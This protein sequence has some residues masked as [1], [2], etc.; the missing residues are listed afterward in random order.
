MNAPARTRGRRL[1]RP[2]AAL[3]AL[4]LLPTAATAAHDSEGFWSLQLENDLWGDNSDRFYTNGWQFSFASSAR[5]PSALRRFAESIP[6]YHTGDKGYFG[7]H[8]GQQVFT[9]EDI[10]ATEL[11]EDDRP[12]AGYLYAETFIGHRYFDAGDRERLNGLILTI[13][14]VGPSSLAEETQELVHSVFDSD[15][16]RGWDNQLDD[17]LGIGVTYV[18]KW[19]Y[20]FAL[21]RAKQYELGLHT[22]LRIGNVYTYAAAGV[23]ARWGTHLKGDIGPPSIKPGFPGLLAFNPQHGNCW[24]LFGGI[25]A[26]AVARNIFLDGNS[27]GDSHSVDKRT[28]I[29]D[30]QIGVAVQLNSARIAFS[31]MLR[32][33]EFGGQ[34]EAEQFGAINF[35]L[36]VD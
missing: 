13:G 30:L 16:P 25:E 4:V 9:P 24:Y 6:Y 10:E 1:P 20:L 31:Q 21:D 28:L 11:I 7:Y 2:V 17:E 15:D 29:G 34:S 23:T 8:I 12:Y 36:H 32:S 22:N 5:A 3:L 19:R 33:R 26:R 18:H 27:D 35:T 14:I